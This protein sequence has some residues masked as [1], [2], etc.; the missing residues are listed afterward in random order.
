MRIMNKKIQMFLLPFAGGSSFSFM[1]LEHFLLKEIDINVVEYAGR[2]S[3]RSEPCFKNYN[4]FLK[5]VIAYISARRKH[6]IP[7]V[8][9]GYSLGSVIA[10]D[11]CCSRRLD[12]IPSYGFLCAEGSILIDNP[13]RGY[14]R[15]SDTK[16]R[17][18]ILALGGIDKRILDNKAIMQEYLGLI[19]N[20]FTVLGQFLYY[21]QLSPC[22]STIIYSPND[23]TCI[24]MKDWTK[25]IK[26]CVDYVEIGDDH[27]FINKM[28]KEVA[29]IV[30]YKI[31]KIV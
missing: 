13:A 29:E 5:D 1:R 24:H 27:F 2:G 28:Y 11:I 31:R 30:N 16:F 6:N 7:Y 9:F 10:F 26:G 3:R 23:P 14:A 12:T 19:R 25:V 22:D 8:V 18:K 21:G 17:E 20:D 15:L 4:D